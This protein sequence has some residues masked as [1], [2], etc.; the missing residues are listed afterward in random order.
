MNYNKVVL[1]GRI[2]SDIELKTTN[3]GQDVLTLRIAVNHFFKQQNGEKKEEAHFF[4][5]VFW[6]GLASTISKYMVKGQVILVEGRLKTS[7][8]TDKENK[9]HYRV[10]VVAESMQMGARPKNQSQENPPVQDVPIS[11]AQN[12]ALSDDIKIEDIPF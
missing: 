5:V 11:S 8:W 6:A 3:L 1:A 10:E 9:I 12:S 7:N 2:A 4:S